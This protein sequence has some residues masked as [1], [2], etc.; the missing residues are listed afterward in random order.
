[1]DARR[2]GPDSSGA[3]A[4]TD[5]A[6]T[7]LVL[8]LGLTFTTGLVD[9]I[10]YLGL[11]RVFAGNMTGN[12][13][14]LGMAL[15]GGGH[16]PVLGPALA[17][18]G[19]LVGAVVGARVD[20]PGLHRWGRRATAAFGLTG[21]LTLGLGVASLLYVPHGH[22][23]WTITVTTLLS[24]AMG[25]QAASAH[26]LA[27]EDVTTVVVTSALTS[28]AA[29][30][31]F[32]GG[33]SR[34]WPRRVLAVVLMLTGAAVGALLLEAGGQRGAGTGLLV[35]GVLILGA[36]TTGHRLRDADRPHHGT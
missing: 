12:I 6:R 11:D 26:R 31:A 25:V 2:A 22:G 13:V 29:D 23:T 30:S 3:S 7:H 27:V 5:P 34:N 1:V 9:A 18:G 32:V 19:F 15:V 16:L 4:P 8:L 20:A 10:G 21:S 36:T 24:V 35:A 33:D 14:I 17:L 28:L